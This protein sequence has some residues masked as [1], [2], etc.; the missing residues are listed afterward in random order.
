MKVF[1]VNLERS[2]VRAKHIKEVLNS[3]SITHE[4]FIAT[5]GSKLSEDKINDIVDKDKINT[6]YG[7][8][9]T[10]GEIGCA[11]SHLR[12]YE[13]MTENNIDI[14]L[15]LEDDIVVD[16]RISE[17]I[18]LAESNIKNFD[19]LHLNYIKPGRPLLKY[20]YEGTKEQFVRSRFSIFYSLAKFPYLLLLSLYEKILVF[21][22]NESPFIMTPKRQVH[23][24]GA[25]FITQSGAR[26]ILE[27]N[28]PIQHVADMAQTIAN[29]KGCFTLKSVA[30]VLVE[31]DH[32]KFVSEIGNRKN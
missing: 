1:V 23:L 13:K 32:K 26:K 15:I 29:N 6:N 27:I 14:A 31:Q 4:L 25:Y 9:L 20:W 3:L 21:I 17:A 28:R 7:R 8:P 16:P 12:I 5:D 10:R 22:H 2:H 19:W 30:P 18:K 24:T 11:D